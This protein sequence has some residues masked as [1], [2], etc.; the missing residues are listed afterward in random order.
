[1]KRILKRVFAAILLLVALLYAGDYVSVR[2]G[3]P[4]GRNSFGTVTIQRYYA[5]KQ[6]D[7]KIEYMFAD[8][9][10]E[11]C[12]NSIFPHMGRRPCWYVNR[13]KVKRIDV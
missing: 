9:Q 1:M 13:H 10:N 8:P 7:G 2:F 11:V 4:R 5:V 6:K 3:I 12:V